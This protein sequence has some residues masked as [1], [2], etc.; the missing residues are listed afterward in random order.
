MP[1]L[2]ARLEAA[3][4]DRYRVDREIG[5]GGMATVYLAQDLKHHRPVALKVL[6]PELAAALGPERFLRE[7]ELSA[8][9]THPHILPLHDSGNADGFLYYVMP[10]VEGE[11]LRERLTRE[12]QLPVDDALQI[13]REVADALSYANSHGVIHRDIKPE[14]ILLE[15]GHAVVADFGI[16]R[17]IDQA[18]GEKLTETGLAIGTPAYMSPEQAMGSGELDGRCDVYA[19][20]CVLYEMLSGEVP[21]TATTPQALFA[22][23]LS[24]PLPRISVVRETVPAAI[25]TALSKALAKVP[26]DR[27]ATV[28]Q[29]AEAIVAGAFVA[30]PSRSRPQVRRRWTG[31][32]GA[33]VLVAAAAATAA[34]MGLFAARGATPIG[35]RPYTI[36]AAF[37]GSAPAA[38]RAAARTLLAAVLDESNVVQAVP[39]DRTQRGLTLAGRADTTPLD[40]GLAY[41]LAVRGGIRT[42]VTGTLDQVGSTF[43]L[44]VRVVDVTDSAVLLTTRERVG[45]EDD[46]LDAVDRAGRQLR[47]GLGERA[48]AIRT[49]RAASEVMTPSFAAYVKYT[50]GSRLP[51]AGRLA[52]LHE[53]LRLDP[54]FAAAWVDAAW[55]YYNMGY[56]DSATAALSEALARPERLTAPGLLACQ[57][58]AAILRNDVPAAVPV[59]REMVEKYGRGHNSLGLTLTRLGRLSDAEEQFRIVAAGPFPSLIAIS[60][61]A[62]VQAKLGRVEDALR[63]VGDLVHEPAIRQWFT[64]QLMLLQQDWAGAESLA[65][66]LDR[67]QSAGAWR[68]AAVFARATVHGVRGQVAKSLQVLDS[69]EAS[70]LAA[71]AQPSWA[72]GG[73]GLLLRYAAS[74]ARVTSF[75]DCPHRGVAEI[76]ILCGL[77]SALAGD[78]ARARGALE[79]L[80]RRPPAALSPLGAGPRVLEAGI[81]VRAGRWEVVPPLLATAVGWLWPARGTVDAGNV[82]RWLVASAYEQLG[83]VDS[84][85]SVYEVLASP[86]EVLKGQRDWNV[87]QG[88]VA[89]S[90][91]HF[92]LGRLYMQLGEYAEAKEHYATFL[93]TFTQPDPEYA[94]MVSEART[95]LEK[96]ARGR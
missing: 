67:D 54:D 75:P 51:S 48:E 2:L 78:T 12:K 3:L 73:A 19:L 60:N 16:A 42:V 74:E 62:E 5:R 96:L 41:E 71:G 28:G 89:F 93:Q 82:A 14:N 10:Y 63:T 1:D 6:M 26:A 24:E 30:E 34:R 52:L 76:L 92:R 64:V 47:R 27:F 53:A 22:K 49:N 50:D 37:D 33:A 38:V 43:A 90:F 40:E 11:S 70:R 81:A 25:E 59:Y 68:R 91:A 15:S 85:A 18:G 58:L 39:E 17:A 56:A 57:G 72:F 77:H 55:S 29:F 7:I 20:G 87:H 46:L 8:R 13:S 61:L 95:E 31:A 44:A 35:P 88:L 66:L 32:V 21:Y 79:I 86:P 4:A 69:A 65:V 83:H 36:V 9:L 45:A 80:S 94:W 84:A 23:K